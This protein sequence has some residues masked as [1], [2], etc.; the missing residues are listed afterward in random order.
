MS[1]LLIDKHVHKGASPLKTYGNM[2]QLVWWVIIGHKKRGWRKKKRE[3]E[4]ERERNQD[5]STKDVEKEE[6]IQN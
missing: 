5:D 2:K 1:E 4:K 3:K 6:I